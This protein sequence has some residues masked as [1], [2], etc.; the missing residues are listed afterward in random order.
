MRMGALKNFTL[1]FLVLFAN[2]SKDYYVKPT[3]DSSCGGKEPCM[4]LEEYTQSL[5]LYLNTTKS[6]EFI[7]NFL[8]G[9]HFIRTNFTV[10]NYLISLTLK[11]VNSSLVN[12]IFNVTC[13]LPVY[14]AFRNIST[15]LNTL[16]LQKKL[17]FV[18]SVFSD[19]SS[20]SGSAIT[21]NRIQLVVFNKTS[22]MSNT[23]NLPRYKGY[24]GA[25]T[26]LLVS[27]VHLIDSTFANNSCRGSGGA[28]FME[29]CKQ[30]VVRN[31]SLANNSAYHGGS[32]CIIIS[33]VYFEVHT[34]FMNNTAKLG[35]AM[36]ARSST[37]LFEGTSV[38][39]GNNA[40][41]GGGA[42]TIVNSSLTGNGSILFV[43]NQGGT[44]GGIVSDRTKIVMHGTT[45]MIDNHAHS[46]G[47]GAF[48]LDSSVSLIGA[49][50]FIN[51]S[52][53]TTGGAVILSGKTSDHVL[54]I[55]GASVLFI[56]NRA[57]SNGG[58]ILAEN[59]WRFA[60][61]YSPEKVRLEIHCTKVIF[62]NNFSDN[63]GGV[64]HVQD[65]L[66]TIE[67]TKE[68]D[69][70]FNRAKSGGWIHA[71]DSSVTIHGYLRAVKN[72]AKDG[73]VITAISSTIFF[74]STNHFIS[75]A[76]QYRGGSIHSKESQITF[77]ESNYFI[78]NSAQY[79][80]VFYLTFNS[81]LRHSL[82]TQLFFINNSA[83]LGGVFYNQDITSMES[84]EENNKCFLDLNSSRQNRNERALVFK[85]NFASQ[86]SALYGGLLDRCYVTRT[87]ETGINNFIESS[88]VNVST[89]ISSAP[90]R[91]CFCRNNV[92]YCGAEPPLLHTYRG[93]RNSVSV[94][95]VDQNRNPKV[96]IIRV[97]FMQTSNAEIGIGQT[98]Q[99]VLENCTLI[100]FSVYTKSEQ[101]TV[102]MYNDGGP[103]RDIGV[104]Q[105]HINITLLPCP[106]GFQLSN[107]QTSCV[108]DKQL[109][110]FT[111]TCDIDTLSVQRKG[112]FWF[113]YENISLILFPY[114]PF[115]Y[116]KPHQQ[117]TTVRIK[118]FDDQCAFNRSG[119]LCGGCQ[120]NLSLSLGSSLCQRCQKFT[121][122]WL[123][124]LFALAGVVLVGFLLV[125]KLTIAVGTI[126]GLLLYANIV[127]ANKAIFFPSNGTYPLTVFIAW[128][129]LD[130][131]IETC[132]YDG[133]DM[134][135]RTWLQFVFPLYLWALVGLIII[136]SH[137][138]TTAAK[139]FGR[140]PVSILATLFLLSYTKILKTIITSFSVSFLRYPVTEE[141][142]AVWLYDGNVQYLAGRHIPLFVTALVF[143][144]FLFL[145]YTLL[146]LFGQ[147]LRKLPRKKGLTWVRSV[148]FTSVMDAYHA[149]YKPKYRFWT[150]LML[151]LRCLLFLVFSF[152][153][154][155]EPSVNL[156]AISTIVLL[157]FLLKYLIGNVYQSKG[158]DILE[159]MYLLNLGTLTAG[160]YHI[161]L[162]N[163]T[164]QSTLGNISMCTAFVMF[165]GTLLYHAFLQI[166]DSRYWKK[167]RSDRRRARLGRNQEQNLDTGDSTDT[168]VAAKPVTR[169]VVELREPL[170]S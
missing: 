80:G 99:K 26:V 34:A 7:M 71:T 6:L 17:F 141:S 127:A 11:R 37:L 153:I 155:G 9:E 157:V 46:H 151:L 73:G 163:S 95:A 116:C 83:F 55:L 117:I 21:V 47:G 131:G 88:T 19:F 169:T 93:K 12:D 136:V 146:I 166:K 145:P 42:I 147:W 109:Q 14:F 64:F 29:K 20:Y 129:N 25:L 111:N 45:S 72:Q 135:S 96:S 149:P 65:S 90:N 38:F 49:T 33:L 140:N 114:C 156:L 51:N 39:I 75:N 132:Y 44:G 67:G 128:L 143:L 158:L 122:I 87:Q 159:V 123:T 100:N 15:T 124:L 61:Y 115:D 77:Y 94:T 24:G 150:G 4:T 119:Y 63:Q 91:I 8:P 138:F 152:N 97:Y 126:N 35:G 5:A 59:T 43:H 165:L 85:S 139:L 36:F 101:E 27:K 32:L 98:L 53:Q 58:A 103:C 62:E 106:A 76:A 13:T 2:S 74:R 84:C 120:N 10:V 30:V 60:N 130:L 121:L 18:D 56:G 86:G 50:S 105:Q 144:L 154:S 134:Y 89:D 148:V 110:S 107:I 69:V 102:F 28:I 118:N 31:V 23:N 104:S 68:L 52:A 170:L 57:G 40:T 41:I 3:S 79:G 161:D 1:L 82:L 112:K 54:Q 168:Y 137:Y 162:I 70:R 78:N 164:S 16:Q 81:L 66:I 48:L 125:C 113:A 142:V 167:Y 133:M 22:F 108:C 160:T 92:P